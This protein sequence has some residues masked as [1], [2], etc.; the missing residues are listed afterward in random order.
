M[1]DLEGSWIGFVCVVGVS[2]LVAYTISSL[3]SYLTSTPL[4]YSSGKSLPAPISLDSK[5]YTKEQLSKHNGRDLDTILVSIQGRV[6]NISSNPLGLQFYGPLGSYR[7]FAG[8]DVTVALAKMDLDRVGEDKCA[9]TPLEEETVQDWLLMFEGK[10]Q[11]CGS[12][13]DY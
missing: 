2:G 7:S 10:Y 9:F 11:E 4:P 12:L 3:V 6:F 8:K 1:S 13:V 5:T